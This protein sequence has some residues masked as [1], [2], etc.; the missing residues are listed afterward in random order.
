MSC[1]NTSRLFEPIAALC[2]HFFVRRVFLQREKTSQ[3]VF[4][5]FFLR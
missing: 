4:L 2:I 5:L 3:C 1:R